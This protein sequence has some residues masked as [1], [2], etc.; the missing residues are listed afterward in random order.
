MPGSRNMLIGLG[1]FILGAV[2][3]G[4]TYAAADD[5]GTYVLAWGPM[6]AGAIQFIIGAFQILFHAL[7]GEDGRAKHYAKLEV[8]AILGSMI[9][10]AIS[11]GTMDENEITVIKN[12][13]ENYTGIEV[14]IETITN[15]S[16]QISSGDYDFYNDLR[17]IRNK[18]SFAAKGMII[19]MAYVVALVDGVVDDKE[20]EGISN[21]ANALGVHSDD[22]VVIIN[23]VNERFSEEDDLGSNKHTPV[24]SKSKGNKTPRLVQ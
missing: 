24:S 18:V 19:R 13:F 21:I 7:R 23:D 20:V 17:S 22:V 8:R 16:S 12:L 1:L 14:N 4:L 11:D 3:T 2:I 5:G 9:H 10:Q 15:I 6:A